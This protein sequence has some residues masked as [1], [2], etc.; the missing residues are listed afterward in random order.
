MAAQIVF[1]AVV[2]SPDRVRCPV[3]A[4]PDGSSDTPTSE[5][6][7]GGLKMKSAAVNCERR[8]VAAASDIAELICDD[9]G[10]TDRVTHGSE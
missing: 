10:T 6:R 3:S 1:S 9:A 7:G 2:L 4:V 8:R 5:V